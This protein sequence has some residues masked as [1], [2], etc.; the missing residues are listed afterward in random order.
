MLSDCSS[1]VSEASGLLAERLFGVLLSDFEVLEARL[2]VSFGSD[3]GL[4]VLRRF[5]DFAAVFVGIS[6]AVSDEVSDA[7][8]FRLRPGI[9]RAISLQ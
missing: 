5:V 9:T 6:A 7:A 4:S 8:A 2:A 1:V 3:I